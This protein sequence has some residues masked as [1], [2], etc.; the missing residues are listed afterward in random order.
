MT[1]HTPPSIGRAEVGRE[2]REK[3]DLLHFISN[4]CSPRADHFG[5]EIIEKNDLLYFL[6]LLHHPRADTL[7]S[8]AVARLVQKMQ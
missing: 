7:F 8:L 1:I 6:H 3:K 5:L 2:K 4:H